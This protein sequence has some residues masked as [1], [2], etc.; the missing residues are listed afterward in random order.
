MDT[1]SVVV[2]VY[3]NYLND[4]DAIPS[5]I[6]NRLTLA[7]KVYARLSKS[8]PSDTHTPIRIILFGSNEALRLCSSIMSINVDT[9]EADSIDDMYARVNEMIESKVCRVYLILSNWQWV[10]VE[11]LLR[12]KDSNVRY[13][14]EGAVDE[15]SIQEIVKEKSKESIVKVKGRR[16][17]NALVDKVMNTL[18]TDMKG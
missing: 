3:C 12:L 13:F 2:A 16:G 17:I 9:M 14:F 7:E 8:Y 6:M 1:E 4:G 15:R 5:H 10:Y 11:P 18:I